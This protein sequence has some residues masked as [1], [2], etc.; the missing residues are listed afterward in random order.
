MP[1]DVLEAG[2]SIEGD[3]SGRTTAERKSGFCEKAGLTAAEHL[4][5]S[6]GCLCY[7]MNPVHRRSD[8]N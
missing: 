8:E 5:P 4:V 2:L 3:A 7:L 6:F 1:D